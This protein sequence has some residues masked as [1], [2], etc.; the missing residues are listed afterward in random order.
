ME[1]GRPLT[2]RQ[3]GAGVLGGVAAAVAGGAA[4]SGGCATDPGGRDGGG[5]AGDERTAAGRPATSPASRPASPPVAVV[6]AHTHFYDPT[7]PQGVPWPPASDPLLYRPVRPAEYLALARPLGVVGTVV[8]EASEWSDDNRYVLG[9]AQSEPALLGL[10]GN[11]SPGSPRFDIELMW[12]RQ[13][14]K[15]RGIRLRGNDWRRWVDG[16]GFLGDLRQLAEAGLQLDLNVGVD[17]LADVAALAERLPTLRIVLNHCANVRIDG[18]AVSAAWLGGMMVLAKRPNVWAKLSGLV[19]GGVP[20]PPPPASDVPEF[21]ARAAT[22]STAATKP[23]P[24]TAPADVE[25][26]RPVLDWMW[27]LFGEDRLIWGSN[28][29][30]SA[31]FAPLETVFAIAHDYVKGRGGHGGVAKVFAENARAAYRWPGR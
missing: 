11:L 22:E 27:A 28:W 20:R 31:R 2:R 23:A 24:A 21:V 6:D 7:R 15:F 10:C 17:G 9:L 13:N 5:R 18:R 25:F 16:D 12:L 4:G 1:N 14:A 26:Y 30:V 19:E 3:F 8:V 29:P